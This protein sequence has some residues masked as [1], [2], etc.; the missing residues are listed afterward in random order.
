M[1]E[2]LK[3]K[4]IKDLTDDYNKCDFYLNNLNNGNINYLNEAIDFSNKKYKEFCIND[5]EIALMNTNFIPTNLDDLS[6][7]KQNLVA[8]KKM[9]SEIISKKETGSGN[10]ACN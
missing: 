3:A 5:T 8:I 9:I 1:N 6:Q 4:E 2:L 10:D 7:T